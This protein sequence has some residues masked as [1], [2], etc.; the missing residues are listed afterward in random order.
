VVCGGGRLI[1]PPLEVVLPD[2]DQPPDQ[3]VFVSR[4]MSRAHNPSE[5]PIEHRYDV[6]R[7]DVHLAAGKHEVVLESHGTAY[8]PPQR[9]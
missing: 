5:A 6:R 8:R 4:H 3:L 7:V 9:M 2:V 1:V